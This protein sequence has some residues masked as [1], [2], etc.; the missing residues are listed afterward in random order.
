MGSAAAGSP[1]ISN[2][3]DQGLTDVM[4]DPMTRR[5]GLVT[6]HVPCR[7]HADGSAVALAGRAEGGAAVRTM[8]DSIEDV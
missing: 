8:R 2:R 3:L 4:D 7:R 5:V 1:A 6:Q